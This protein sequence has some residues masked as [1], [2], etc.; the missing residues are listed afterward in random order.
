LAAAAAVVSFRNGVRDAPYL[1][2]KIACDR[3]TANE[4]ATSQFVR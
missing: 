2:M 3:I 4:P 1:A